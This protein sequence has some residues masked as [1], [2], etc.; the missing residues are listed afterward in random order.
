MKAINVNTPDTV[1]NLLPDQ[2]NATI[3]TDRGGELS[4]SHDMRQTAQSHG[5]EV[6]TTATDASS[7]NGIVKR[8]HRTL[9]EKIRCMLYSSR[10]V[11]NFGRTPSC[12]QPG[13]IIEHIT[14]RLK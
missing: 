7:Q 6:R 13:C 5:Y 14:A 10:L 1:F 11:R 8:P 12:M 9:K 4:A 3:T 2:I